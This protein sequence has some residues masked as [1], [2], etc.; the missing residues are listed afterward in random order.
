MKTNRNLNTP[1]VTNQTITSSL[2]R[3]NANGQSRSNKQGI[4]II[5]ILGGN[6]RLNHRTVNT[7]LNNTKVTLEIITTVS[8][9]KRQVMNPNVT[10]SRPRRWVRI[11]NPTR[12]KRGT[13]GNLGTQSP[14][15]RQ[16]RFRRTVPRMGL[17]MNDII[18]P[19]NKLLGQPRVEGQRRPIGIGQGVF[20]HPRVSRNVHLNRRHLR[21][22]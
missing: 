13:P 10:V 9:N 11:F 5:L 7:N 14:H 22:L 1:P 3:N 4:M 20:Y 17:G 16:Q 18:W 8:H 19:N 21:P 2:A 12:I 15:R 6:T